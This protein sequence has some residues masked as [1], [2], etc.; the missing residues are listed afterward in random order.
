[1]QDITGK[2][3]LDMLWH[4]EKARPSRIYLRQPVDGIWHDYSFAQVADQVRRIAAAIKAQNYPAGSHIAIAGRNCAHWFIADLAIAMAGHVSVGL[5][6]KQA[7]DAVSYILDHCE[8]R[9]IFIGPMQEPESILNGIPPRVKRVSMPYPDVAPGDFEWEDWLQ[10]YRPLQGDIV[11]DP[12]KA[13]TLVYTS[14]TTGNPK[15]V[16]LKGAAMMFA[17]QGLL[18]VLD[19]GDDERIFS[20]L[21]LA[22]IFERGAVELFSIYTGAQV[23]F[24]ESLDKFAEQVAEVAPTRFIAVPAVWA[25]IQ[26]G[27]LKK[28]PQQKLDRLLKIPV[29]SGLIRK[30]IKTGLGLQNS[31]LNI[32]GAA[33]IPVSTLEWFN[34]LGIPI[35]QGYGMTENCAY[36]SVNLPDANKFGSVGRAVPGCEIRLSEQ[37]EILT[38]SPAQMTGYYKELEKTAE[39]LADGWIHTGDKGRIDEDGYLFITGRVKDIF[40]TLKGKYVAPAPIEGKIAVNSHIEMLC[41]VGAGLKQPVALAVLSEN[42]RKLSQDQVEKELAA[43]L[44]QVNAGLE[45]HE[46][47]AGIVLIKEA[48]SI[49]NGFLTP[50]MKIKRHTVEERYAGLVNQCLESKQPVIWES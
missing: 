29:V 50:T 18:G 40:K 6:P 21:P 27:I 46:A 4:W 31:R 30:K 10:Q 2:A 11:P 1:M 39:T 49:D 19:P 17:L 5:Y 38:R 12:E 28:L 9:L 26:Q 42:A 34:K 24:L 25:R 44:E 41:L 35:M 15:G 3:P 33:A 43:S 32:T 45:A 37:G 13:W 20:Y 7:T 14:G 23:S 47:V 22:H 48:W 16:E 36:V 8:A